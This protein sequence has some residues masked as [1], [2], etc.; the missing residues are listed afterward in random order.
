M[1]NAYSRPAQG[2]L[3]RRVW[4]IAD[5]ESRGRLASRQRV[6]ERV[7]GE[8]GNANTASTQYHHWRQA[9][10]AQSA[11]GPARAPTTD[12][13]YFKVELKEAGRILL[14][15]EIRAAMGI[16]EG[17]VLT[18]VVRDGELRLMSR[19]TAIR[20]AQK[21]VRQHVPEGVS[22]V[23]DLIAERRAEN[24]RESQQ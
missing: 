4:D 19:D 10:A 18:G 15:A 3:T 21:L 23:D 9:R 16:G 2:T 17:A 22:L 11:Q 14:P 20:Q 1:S 13:V 24:A 12:P 5:E 8:G 6:I 7:V